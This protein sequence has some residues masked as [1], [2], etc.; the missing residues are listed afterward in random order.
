MLKGI[1]RLI[2]DTRGALY[3]QYLLVGT[4][5]LALLA[6]SADYL[7]ANQRVNQVE[8]I[9][10][11]AMDRV[12]LEGCLLPEDEDKIIQYLDDRGFKDIVIDAPRDERIL[13]N[14]TDYTESETWLKIQCRVYPTP[15]KTTRMA[16]GFSEQPEMI[17][18]VGGRALSERVDP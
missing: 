17:L 6:G 5:S 16:F 8:H 12:R 4:M 7:I 14:I 13:R 10:E 18:K 15:F 3:V 11:Y 2:K 9:K 1:R